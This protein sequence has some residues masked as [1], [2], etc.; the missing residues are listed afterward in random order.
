MFPVW[1]ESVLSVRATN[2]NGCFA[3]LNPSKSEHDGTVFG[4]WHGRAQIW[5]IQWQLE[6]QH[7]CWDSQKE[8][9]WMMLLENRQYSE[10]L[11]FPS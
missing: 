9:G 4:F 7:S 8:R 2:T 6:L 3:E 5:H 10:L 11:L 1:Q